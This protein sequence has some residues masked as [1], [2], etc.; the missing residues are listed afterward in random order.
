MMRELEY[1]F[2]EERLRGLYLFSL[3][4]RQL[5]ED[6]IKG[7]KY[8]KIK[9]QEDRVIFLV[10]PSERG[11]GQQAHTGTCELPSDQEEKFPLRVTE[12]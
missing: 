4:K 11:K 3:E 10:V 1:L 8:L 5:R 9:S 2:C 12:P 6:L 7:Y